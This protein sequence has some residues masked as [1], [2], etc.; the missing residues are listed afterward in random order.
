[1]QAKQGLSADRKQRVTQG[2]M[3][4]MEIWTA[5]V[6]KQSCRRDAPETTY[7]THELTHSEAVQMRKR[8]TE[9]FSFMSLEKNFTAGTFNKL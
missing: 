1:M 6:G 5:G 8:F 3:F 9:P 2:E 7:F 4:V